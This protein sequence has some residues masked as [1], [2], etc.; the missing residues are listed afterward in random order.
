MLFPSLPEG[1]L[2]HC[3]CDSLR[4]AAGRFGPKEG[5]PSEA[6]PSRRDITSTRLYATRKRVEE[7]GQQKRKRSESQQKRKRSES[8][9]P[10][11][12]RVLFYEVFPLYEDQSLE[13]ET[14]REFQV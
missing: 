1:A 11:E 7:R 13:E 8:Q 6:H 10:R 3:F 4:R 12:V 14:W 5:S 2:L 9:H